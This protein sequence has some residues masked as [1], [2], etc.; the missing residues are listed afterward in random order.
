M[1]TED[2][3]RISY[4]QGVSSGDSSHFSRLINDSTDHCSSHVSEDAISKCTVTPGGRRYYVPIAIDETFIPF[5]N[6]LFDS[7]ERGMNF[8]QEYGM[9]SGFNTRRST[10]K[11][12]D[13]NNIVSKYVVCSRA[14]FN[15]KKSIVPSK[16]SSQVRRR[17]TVSNR[18]GCHAKIILRI[19]SGKTYRISTFVEEHNHDLVA[20]DG[21]QFMRVNRQMSTIS[22]K[23]VFDAANVNI[24]V[25]KSHSFM[26]EQVGGY[27][28]VGATVR[29]FRNFSR[30]LKAY[31]GERDT[32]MI[33]NKFKA[34][35]DSCE[36]F[37]YAY[38]VDSEDHLT[39]LFCADTVARRNYELYGDV[40][41]FDAT[42]N[43]NMY[44]MVFCPF[45]GVDKHD[46]CVTFGFAL[47]S[48]EDIPHFQ[49]AFNHF[50]KAMDRNP[51]V[52]VTDQCPAMKQAIPISFAATD[53]FPATRHR[54]CMWHIMEKFPMKL[55][56]YLCK[57]PDYME[58]N[59]KV[60]VS[61]NHAQCSCK[62]FVFCGILCR[63]A[64]CAL[65]HFEVVKMPRLFVLNR[66]SRNAENRPSSSKFVGVS[67]DFRKIETVSLTVTNIWFNFQ[68]SMNKAESSY[69]RDDGATTNGRITIHAPNQCKNKGSGLK[70]FVSQREKAIKEGNKRPRKCKFCSS[71]VH[72]ARTCP[73]K[74][75]SS[76]ADKNHSS[77][78]DA[79]KNKSSTVDVTGEVEVD[80]GNE[81]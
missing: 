20:K 55:G 6:K 11:T 18:C 78:A 9:L 13:D 37:Y 8:Y 49:W 42:F 4:N 65:N 35:H 69:G 40:V 5:V 52:I 29:D 21:R 7:M 44:N 14:G 63:H 45:T 75:N 79:E 51:V 1:I 70:R 33:I 80:S 23:F 39:K 22:R 19:I 68:K 77:T 43:T 10:E 36:S 24:R 17:R 32:Q 67:D 74:N 50:R 30:D 72:D 71:S 26:K 60:K 15:E 47:L 76:T 3:L 12:D 62:K 41:S 46:K 64:F 59:E 66:W 53:D 54:L 56:N 58:K 28:N 81:D 25:S 38:D 73:Q 61:R 16:N 48:K 2:L 31:V 57:E 34:K 27:A